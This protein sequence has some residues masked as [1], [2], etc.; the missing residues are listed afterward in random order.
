MVWLENFWSFG[1][2]HKTKQQKQ[3]QQQQQQQQQHLFTGP[4]LEFLQNMLLK[5]IWTPDWS[6][7]L[8]LKET[9]LYCCVQMSKW[10]ITISAWNTF[11]PLP[12]PYKHTQTLASHFREWF[13]WRFLFTWYLRF[14]RGFINIFSWRETG[15]DRKAKTL[16]TELLCKINFLRDGQTSQA[17]SC[18]QLLN[19]SGAWPLIKSLFIL[20]TLLTDLV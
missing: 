8:Y 7:T 6:A 16:W 18:S 14:Y 17:K 20:M 1:E 19:L 4:Y 11:H 2:A 13:D 12:L 10:G 3:Q 15:F 5:L 9:V